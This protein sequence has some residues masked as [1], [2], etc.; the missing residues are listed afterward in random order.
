MVISPASF[1][2]KK[3]LLPVS[4]IIVI[5]SIRIN[6]TLRGYMSIM[7]IPFIKRLPLWC[8]LL[9]SFCA[10]ETKGA[11]S[12]KLLNN[13]SDGFIVT[14]HKEGM[15]A[16]CSAAPVI[17]LGLYLYWVQWNKYRQQIADALI[18]T[19]VVAGGIYVG[20]M[21]V[22]PVCNN[23]HNA[24]NPYYTPIASGSSA[25]AK[26]TSSLCASLGKNSVA[27][28]SRFLGFAER[29]PRIALMSLGL[30]LVMTK[31]LWRPWLLPSNKKQAGH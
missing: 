4:Y 20:S 25:L 14:I 28:G 8:M 9:I 7:S 10:Q 31:D 11:D 29:H 21:Y 19:S 26:E 30:G 13:V 16:M 5:I 24:L 17:M 18:T 6:L 2:K 27:L 3:S 22:L 15:R 1:L 23:I 12:G